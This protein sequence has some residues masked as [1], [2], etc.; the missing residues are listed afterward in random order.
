MWIIDQPWGGV[1]YMRIRKQPLGTRNI[2]GVRVEQQRKAINMKQKDLLAQLQIRGIE[3]NSSG[4]SK[5]EGQIRL[6][7]DFELVALADIL[8]VSINWLVGLE[9]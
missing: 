3:M 8:G 5:L 7:T 2:V 9:K 1:R 6:V 4:L